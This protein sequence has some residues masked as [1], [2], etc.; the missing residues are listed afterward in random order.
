MVVGEA[1]V[2]L[3]ISP[4]GTVDAALG[5]APFNTARTCGRLGVEVSFVGAL[6]SDRFGTLLRSRLE[7]DGVDTSG[8]VAVDRPTTL[9]AAE[10]DQGGAASYRFYIDGTSAPAVA[11]VSAAASRP[12]IVFTGGLALVLEPLADAVAAMLTGL[13][14]QP[15]GDGRGAGTTT[16]PQPLVVVDV[17]CRP[18]VV[19]DRARYLER[20]HEVLARTQVVKVSDDDLAYLSP[21][22]EPDEAARRLLDVGPSVVLLT[23]GSGAVTIHTAGGTVSV[24]V[25]PVEVVDTIG[26]GDAFGGGFCAWWLASGHTT[27]DLADPAALRRAVEAANEVAAIVCT[28]RGAD[29]PWRHELPDAWSG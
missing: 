1:L 22:V 6:S 21:G 25:E 9:A 4:D 26:A 24:P 16:S 28:R 8:A 17:N 5:G 11:R 23:A 3:V 19:G 27:A 20:L 10:L 13:S 29:P 15:A 18:L 14:G 12:A 7:H 2:D